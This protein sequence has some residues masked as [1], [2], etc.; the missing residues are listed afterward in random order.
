MN[1]LP[2]GSN[3]SQSTLAAV[4]LAALAVLAL[5]VAP[6]GLAGA[7]PAG[8]TPV[9]ACTTIDTPG[10]YVLTEN[11]TGDVAD[12]DEACIEVT[13]GNVT[14]DGAGHSVT[15]TGTGHGVEV[16]GAQTPVT[17]V[18]VER[19]H[20]NEW[21][22]GV[23]LLGVDDSTVR[24]VVANG[25]ISGVSLAQSGES[26]VVDTTAYNNSIGI[27]VGG[28]SHNNT[29]RNAV[30]VQNKW[31]IHFERES[32]NNTVRNSVA[33]NNSNW[34]YYGMRN[35]GPNTV[36]NLE[37]STATLSFT[38]QNVA[39]RSITDPPALP[40]GTANRGAYVEAFAAAGD[41]S[42]SLTMDDGAGVGAATLW[43]A[44]QG[45]WS[46][47]PGATSD[48]GT[49]S[50][51]N[52]TAFGVFGALS[53]SG[54]GG[55]ANVTASDS[56][57]VQRT[58]TTVPGSAATSTA[59]PATT[60][61]TAAT[62]V[63]SNATGVAAGANGS[64]AADES[65]ERPGAEPGT[66]ASDGSAADTAAPETGDAGGLLSSTVGWAKVIFAAAALVALVLLGTVVVIRRRRGRNRGF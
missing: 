20:A 51:A 16:D 53:D 18:T 25:T 31:G 10:R 39:F 5:A 45:S 8:A 26:R 17:N 52:L 32:G 66:A 49:V 43:R 1:A 30:A 55:P 6:V 41:S 37:L 19:L 56:P 23:F 24:N 4:V 9:N 54:N 13:S 61:A 38:A 48:G 11:V 62:S 36:S 44:S 34:D 50:G 33:R 47:V 29:V 12:E 58:M 22:V 28:M 60:D 42:L 21:T 27:A 59:T 46:R 3:R 65:T 7:Q 15:G 35:R 57:S 63:G 14:L 2:A 40:A 64:T